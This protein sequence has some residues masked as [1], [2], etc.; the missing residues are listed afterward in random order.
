MGVPMSMVIR[1]AVKTTAT[2]TIGSGQGKDPKEE[3]GVKGDLRVYL[4]NKPKQEEK[5]SLVV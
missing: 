1:R 2:T 3:H 5:G 4:K